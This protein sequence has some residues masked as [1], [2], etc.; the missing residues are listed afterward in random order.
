MRSTGGA[1]QPAGIRVLCPRVGGRPVENRALERG[2]H[3][4]DF[5]QSRAENLG[6]PDAAEVAGGAVAAPVVAGEQEASAAESDAGQIGSA[7]GEL[8][9][10]FRRVLPEA[11][12]AS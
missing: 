3:S 6:R 10:L 8:V 4:V 7:N 9:E 5:G 12:R 1:I 11:V 2:G